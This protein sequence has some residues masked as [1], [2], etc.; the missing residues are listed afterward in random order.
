MRGSTAP[1]NLVQRHVLVHLYVVPGSLG[2][3]PHTGEPC[4]DWSAHFP[5]KIADLNPGARE[6][7]STPAP[8]IRLWGGVGLSEKSSRGYIATLVASADTNP[9]WE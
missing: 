6:L 3:N 9:W 4:S 2:V 5:S 8:Q 1:F 7:L